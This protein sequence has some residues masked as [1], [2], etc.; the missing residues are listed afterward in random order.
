MS[1][2][3]SLDFSDITFQPLAIGSKPE[4]LAQ[5]IDRQHLLAA[6]RAVTSRY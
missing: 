3:L 2:N 5:Y 6:D 1:D 4:E